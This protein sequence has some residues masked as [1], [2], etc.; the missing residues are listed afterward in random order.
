MSLSRTSDSESDLTVPSYFILFIHFIR[1]YEHMDSRE[2]FA[3]V[4]LI[5]F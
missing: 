3:E 2:T 1:M 5:S 4:P